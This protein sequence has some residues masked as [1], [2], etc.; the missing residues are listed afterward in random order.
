M[1][2]IFFSAL[3]ICFPLVVFSNQLCCLI[4]DFHIILL[5]YV[6]HCLELQQQNLLRSNFPLFSISED[7][8][9]QATTTTEAFYGVKLSLFANSLNPLINVQIIFLLG[10]LFL[11][12]L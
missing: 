4:D 12:R 8:V 2:F 7:C 11:E 10:L 3:N 9:T 6:I 1:M 5:V